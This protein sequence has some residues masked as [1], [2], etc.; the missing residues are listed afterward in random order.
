MEQTVKF[1]KEVADLSNNEMVEEAKKQKVMN[2]AVRGQLWPYLSQDIR[3]EYDREA[4]DVDGN[5][6]TVCP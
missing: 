4:R 5:A 2:K 6:R 3:D 1:R